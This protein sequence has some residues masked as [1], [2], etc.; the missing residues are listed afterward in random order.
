MGQNLSWIHVLDDHEIHN[1]WD[2]YVF[3]LPIVCSPACY[4]VLRKQLSWFF[5]LFLLL[6]FT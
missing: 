2:G 1:D 5:V 3:P 4:S 6:F